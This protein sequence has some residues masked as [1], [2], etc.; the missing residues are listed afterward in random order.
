MKTSL[1]KELR[2]LVLPFV[3]L[4]LVAYFAVEAVL[5]DGAALITPSLT[6]NHSEARLALFAVLALAFWQFAG[7][8]MRGTHTYLVLRGVG[9]G[10]LF[11]AK[12]GAG[13]IA[14]ATA[15][16]LSL[17]FHLVVL[18][19]SP[20]ALLF[21][22]F[23][24]WEV[25][26]LLIAVLPVY[27]IGVL[28]AVGWGGGPR[29]LVGRLALS[30]LASSGLVAGLPRVLGGRLGSERLVLQAC[31]LGCVLAITLWL[32]R[33]R[34]RSMADADV[35]EAPVRVRLRA[36]LLLILV[37]GQLEP[38]VWICQR[39][40]RNSDQ[41][42]AVVNEEG[43]FAELRKARERGKFLVLDN[44]G[45]L[46]DTLEVRLLPLLADESATPEELEKSRGWRRVPAGYQG[47]F[48][49]D[50]P[51][52]D[53]LGRGRGGPGYSARLE[54]GFRPELVA[55]GE[56]VMERRAVVTFPAGKVFVR[57]RPHPVSS[58]EDLHRASR[59]DL[60]SERAARFVLDGPK[61]S[62]R[63][64]FQLRLTETSG[65][66]RALVDPA[67]GSVMWIEDRAGGLQLVEGDSSD[68][69]MTEDT[70]S[71]SERYPALL[72]RL[73]KRILMGADGQPV[74][75]WRAPVE[76]T[77]SERLR[78]INRAVVTALKPTLRTVL[79]TLQPTGLAPVGEPGV[80]IGEPYR[81]DPS[82]GWI[83]PDVVGFRRPVTSLLAVGLTLLAAI[84][85]ARRE[86][87]SGRWFWIGL[88]AVCGLSGWVAWW[89][90]RAPARR[91]AAAKREITQAQSTPGEEAPE[92][93]AA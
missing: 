43:R 33:A 24:V 17:A 30:V 14:V 22:A 48:E 40:L 41:V 27:G 55:V 32:A 58:Q 85:V 80:R 86:R 51:R 79:G 5:A 45:A 52:R 76:P 26:A 81:P 54:V 21:E 78:A 44:T 28:L 57:Y 2:E 59:T 3:G 13:L 93:L 6:P 71:L 18:S 10:H 47:W 4:L 56:G 87:G 72:Y 29:D 89:I 60:D 34:F 7:E 49:R 66:S 15:F 1:F 8:R 9:R 12:A 46:L 11:L 37:I 74:E 91:E 73:G 68:L 83:S 39:V 35:P 82:E 62:D 50:D 31:L 63:T 42:I 64:Y 25:I 36:A 65:D 19:E 84:G 88:T 90:A 23:G 69:A 16:A 20:E 77:R 61:M 92:A 75:G 38:L 70:S 53:T 67:S